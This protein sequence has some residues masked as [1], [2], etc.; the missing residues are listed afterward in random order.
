[1]NANLKRLAAAITAFE[2]V[3]IGYPKDVHEILPQSRSTAEVAEALRSLNVPPSSRLNE[4]YTL[5]DGIELPQIDNAYSILTLEWLHRVQNM[6]SEPI[7]FDGRDILFF[8]ADGGGGR[9]VLALDSDEVYYLPVG[10]V[11]PDRVYVGSDIE[12]VAATVDE[13]LVQLTARVQR[14][15]DQ[16]S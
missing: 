11:T 4:L 1:M 10:E 16:G 15:T 5:C 14:A 3:D 13:W 8:G 6:D 2:P 9:F 7:R 12:L